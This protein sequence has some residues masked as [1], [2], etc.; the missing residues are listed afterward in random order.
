MPIDEGTVNAVEGAVNAVVPIVISLVPGAGVASPFIAAGLPALE[1]IL[2][3]ALFTTSS[4]KSGFN[5]EAGFAELMTHLNPGG[6][7]SAKLS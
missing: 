5:W 3:A 4:T 7:N 1:K 2:N 6:A